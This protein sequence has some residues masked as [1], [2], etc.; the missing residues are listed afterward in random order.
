MARLR[1]Q[2][3]AYLRFAQAE[4]GLFRAAF[5]HDAP[6]AGTSESYALLTTALDDLV[7]TGVMDRDTTNAGNIME[8]L[9]RLKAKAETG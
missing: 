2:G 5:N 3:R 6:S 7:A 8:T 9:H 1:A 4:P